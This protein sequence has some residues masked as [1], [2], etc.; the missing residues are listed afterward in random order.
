MDYETQAFGPVCRNE[1]EVV[2]ALCDAMRGGCQMKPEYR[3]R[4]DRFFAFDDHNN[5]A[6]IYEAAMSMRGKS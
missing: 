2:D 4:A 5:C 3:A 6:R 1:T